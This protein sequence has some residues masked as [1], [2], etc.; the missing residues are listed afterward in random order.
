M[1][2]CREGK[3][4]GGGDG[5]AAEATGEVRSPLLVEAPLFLLNPSAKLPSLLPVLV[6]PYDVP[7]WDENEDDMC[8]VPGGEL[9]EMAPPTATLGELGG[10]GMRNELPLLS[11][12]GVPLVAL[13]SLLAP[14]DPGDAADVVV[15]VADAP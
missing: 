6:L 4:G 10:R 13:L 12:V 7:S 3:A 9:G 1:E 11:R 2:A 15:D 14:A 5:G 8:A